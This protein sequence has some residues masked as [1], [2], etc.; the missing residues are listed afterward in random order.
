MNNMMFPKVVIHFVDGFLARRPDVL[1]P[2]ISN[3]VR[4]F[5]V[6]LSGHYQQYQVHPN[7]KE[8]LIMV[9]GLLYLVFPLDCIPDYIPIFGYFDDMTVLYLIAKLLSNYVSFIDGILKVIDSANTINN[10]NN[11][12]NNRFEDTSNDDCAICFCNNGAKNTKLVPRGHK[13]CERHTRQ[14]L[15]RK[16]NCPLCRSEIRDAVL[17]AV[18]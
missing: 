1:G 4:S 17:T 7:K 12:N 18:V 8:S 2:F 13:F 10:I 3:I 6:S 9:F 11:I 16:M 15:S 5:L 14:L